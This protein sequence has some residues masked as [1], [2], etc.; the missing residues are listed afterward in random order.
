MTAFATADD[1]AGRLGR[2]FTDAEET[3]VGELLEDAASFLRSVIEQDVFPRRQSTYTAYPTAGREV[4]PQWPVVSVDAVTRNGSAVDYT[5]RP[6]A[7]TVTGDDPVDITFTW[8]YSEA[9]RELVRHSC[10]LASQTLFLI[11]SKIGLALGG[12]SSAQID[13]FRVAWADAGNFAGMSLTPQAERIL[14]KTFGRGQVTVVEA[15]A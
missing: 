15:S 8:G 12:L 11:E 3:L 6:P 4:L 13:D 7:V 1:L 5:Y 14:L 2:T 10:V 9:P